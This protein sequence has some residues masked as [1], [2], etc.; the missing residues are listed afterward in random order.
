MLL[1]R[2]ISHATTLDHESA[3]PPA[4]PPPVSIIIPARNEA[5]NI[6]ACVRSMLSSSY[7]SFEILVV[8]DRSSDATHEIA[9]RISGE[10]SRVRVVRAEPLPDGWFGQQWALLSGSKHAGGDILCFADADTRHGPELLTRSVNAILR[11]HADLFSVS[12]RQIFG[13]AWERIVQPQLLILLSARYGGTEDVTLA[14]RE[15]DKLAGGPCIFVTRSAYEEVGRHSVAKGYIATDVMLARGF[16]RNGKK[17][18]LTHSGHHASVRMYQS[19]G[20]MIRGWSKNIVL[21]TRISSGSPGAADAIKTALLFVV[22]LYQ[23]LPLLAIVS[24]VLASSMVLAMWGAAASVVVL[25]C[26]LVVYRGMEQKAS[27]AFLSPAGA[28]VLLFILARS[29]LRG[30]R[31]AWAGR[32]YVSR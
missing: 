12:C 10:D 25:C 17:V 27:Y 15:R 23:L 14:T 22:P 8:D 1:F 18:V 13:T 2:R 4:Q 19:L 21:G 7:P 9:S 20:E 29:V 31:V 32:E 11:R 26:W 5:R 16:F 30:R 28:G 6:E 24:G 3:E